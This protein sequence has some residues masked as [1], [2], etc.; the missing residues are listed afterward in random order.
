LIDLEKIIK[1]YE[2]N[3]Y[4]NLSKLNTRTIEGARK[5]GLKRYV[6]PALEYVCLNYMCVQGGQYQSRSKGLRLNQK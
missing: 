6:N 3:E 4:C 5:K 2:I 1:Q